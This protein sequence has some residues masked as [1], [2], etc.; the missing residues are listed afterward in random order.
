MKLRVT[1]A[2]TKFHGGRY[3]I[4]YNP[5][6]YYQAQRGTYGGTVEGPEVTS[7]LVQPYG[8]SMI[9]DMKD[10]NIFDFDIPYVSESP[11]LTFDSS[12]GSI[13]I[14]CID[15]LQASSSVTSTVPFVVEVAGGPDYEVADFR[16][17]MFITQVDGTIYQQSGA[18][19]TATKEPSQYTIGE[20]ITSVKQMIQSPSWATISVPAGNFTFCANYPWVVYGPSRNISIGKGLPNGATIQTPGSGSVG[21]AI[22]KCYAFYRGGTDMHVY[23]AGDPTFVT[24]TSEQ[25]APAGPVFTGLGTDY[26]LPGLFSSTPKVYSNGLYG[27]HIRSP[28][29]HYFSRNSTIT[30]D[31]VGFV[32][33]AGSLGGATGGTQPRIHY[34]VTTIRN[35]GSAAATAVVGR[36][37]A[38]DAMLAHYMGPAPIYIPNILNTNRLDANWVPAY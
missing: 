29:F 20:R 25:V 16:G 4:S 15:P 22:A 30:L 17:C 38:D 35:N 9:M 26:A 7:S 31:N 24:V 2:K 34:D 23:I 14:V 1:F 18:I 37:A 21:G 19:I 5:R 10:G 13:S 11:Y 32:P 36:A 28:G 8:Y 27:M 33:F 3:M 12:S 6:T